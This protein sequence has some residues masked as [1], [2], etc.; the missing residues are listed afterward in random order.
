MEESG[1]KTVVGWIL[2]NWI[3]LFIFT[4]LMTIL[5]LFIIFPFSDLKDVVTGVVA[6]AT[7][8]SVFLTYDDAGLS[9]SNGLGLKVDGVQVEV[10]A[11]PPIKLNSA[12][13]APSISAITAKA[14]LGSIGL[15]GL[16]RGDLSGNLGTVKSGNDQFFAVETSADKIQLKSLLGYVKKANL[17][18]SSFLPPSVLGDLNF[19]LKATVDPSANVQPQGELRGVINKLNLESFTLSMKQRGGFTIDIEIP[20][21]KFSKVNVVATMQ[22]REVKITEV[23]MGEGNDGLK[24]LMTGTMVAG[25]D[26][27]G[28]AVQFSTGAFD[29]E[30]NME[31]LT[32]ALNDPDIQNFYNYVDLGLS[33]CKTRTA[34]GVRYK[35]RLAARSFQ[36]QALPKCI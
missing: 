28:K 16:F 36:T 10:S 8:N 11:L 6:D 18:N 2:G 4:P 30:F 31:F 19:D 24:I 27:R 26:K 17:V 20:S 7:R 1:L 9:L 15:S 12:S 14:P 23:R 13:F 33:K 21:L 25:L 5:F 3:K 29:F 34:N 22:E 35:F 32:K